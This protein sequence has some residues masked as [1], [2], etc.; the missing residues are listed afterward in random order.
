MSQASEFLLRAPAWELPEVAAC[1]PDTQDPRILEAYRDAAAE[2]AAGGYSLQEARRHVYEVLQG[3]GY[4]TTP[5]DKGTM[6]DFL[7]IPRMSSTLRTLCG[8]ARGWADFQ[9]SRWDITNPGRELYRATDSTHPQD[10][11]SRWVEEAAAVNWEGVAKGGQMVALDTS[12]IW[13]KLSRFGYPYPPFDFNS[14]M[15]VRV[16]SYDDCEALGLNVE[17]WVEKRLQELAEE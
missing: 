14:G 6:R 1:L 8:L 2:M 17:E 9:M 12:P 16:V 15:R 7:H 13:V 10:W 3:M 4:T 5:E 11:T